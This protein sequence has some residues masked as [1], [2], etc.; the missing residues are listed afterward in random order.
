MQHSALRQILMLSAVMLK[1][2]DADYRN[3]TAP[4]KKMQAIV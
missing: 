4:F 2:I 3:G 1:I